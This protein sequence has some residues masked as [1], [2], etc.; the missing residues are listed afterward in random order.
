VILGGEGR[1]AYHGVDRIHPLDIGLAEQ[2][3][4]EQSDAAARDET[5][6]FPTPGNA[7]L[8]QR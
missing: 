6:N 5:A 3:R 2:R 7:S 4:P 1:L 8:I